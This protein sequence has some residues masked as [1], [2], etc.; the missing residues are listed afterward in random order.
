MNESEESDDESGVGMAVVVALEGPS[1]L[2]GTGL[3]VIQDEPINKLEDDS[4]S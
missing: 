3:S 1:A 2:G 4:L